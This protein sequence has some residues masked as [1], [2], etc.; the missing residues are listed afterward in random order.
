M[1]SVII[2]ASLSRDLLFDTQMM[3]YNVYILARENYVS[4]MADKTNLVLFLFSYPRYLAT[5]I[6][7]SSL[8]YPK[9]VYLSNPYKRGLGVYMSGF[10]VPVDLITRFAAY[11]RWVFLRVVPHFKEPRRQVKI[12]TTSQ[13]SQWYYTSKCKWDK[14]KE[15]S[16]N[17]CTRFT[18]H[19]YSV[20]QSWIIKC[21]IHNYNYFS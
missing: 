8:L 12:Q 1:I 16:C 4:N 21:G 13:D 15:I 5:F 18:C 10:G 14:C 19:L 20:E 17:I 9:H 3:Y 6:L 11:Y 7:I 2:Q